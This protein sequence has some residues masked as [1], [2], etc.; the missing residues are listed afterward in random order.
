MEN[1]GYYAFTFA[2]LLASELRQVITCAIFSGDTQVSQSLQYSVDT[3]GN[4]KSGN[5]SVLC[6]A[7]IAY[8]DAA[9]DYFLA[10]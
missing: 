6:K 3:Y 1:K 4:G 2:N 7:M 10:L 9:K 8:S 5:L